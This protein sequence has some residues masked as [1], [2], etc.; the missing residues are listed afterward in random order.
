MISSLSNPQVKEIVLL[1]T[2][3]RARRDSGLFV[4]EGLRLV[5]E[6]PDNYLVKAFFA[7]GSDPGIIELAAKINAEEVSENVFRKMSSTQTPQG[8]L[9]VARRPDWTLEDVCKA[10][11][12]RTIMILEDIQDPGNLGTII[13]TGEGAGISGIIATHGTADLTNPKTVRSTMGSIFRVPYVVTDDLHETI[14]S[15][16]QRG[17]TIYAAALEGSVLYDVPDYTAPSAF[18]IGNEGNGLTA[19]AYAAADKAVRIPM[20]GMVESLNAAV[21][22]AILMY[23]ARRQKQRVIT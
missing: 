9:A 7:E 14:L 4:A 17:F 8:I 2:K 23:E 1:Q 11:V 18:L 12:C 21:A 16:K 15:L 3:P 6:I 10:P 20:S 13:R 22:S 5:E 19:E